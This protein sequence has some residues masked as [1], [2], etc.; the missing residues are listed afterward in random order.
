MWWSDGRRGRKLDELVEKARTEKIPINSFDPEAMERR[1]SYEEC[2][3]Q[4]KRVNFDQRSAC[5][6]HLRTSS[7][8]S[9]VMNFENNTLV[10]YVGLAG[11]LYIVDC[12]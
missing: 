2:G 9:I 4:K 12:T 11:W 1:T 6:D 3:G 5:I 8:T 7:I 10:S